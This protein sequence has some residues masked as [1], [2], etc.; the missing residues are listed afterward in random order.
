MHK[1][2]V[3]ILFGGHSSEY[4]VSLHSVASVIENIDTKKYEIFLFGI[5]Q[6]GN[7]M[8]YEGDVTSIENDTWHQYASA[9][10]LSLNP[11]D[12]GFYVFK[13]QSFS[14]RQVDVVFPV[15]HG[16]YGEDGTLQGALSMAQ[17]PYVGCDT[18]SSSVSMDKEFTHILC[19]RFNI[20]MAPYYALRCNDEY[21]VDSLFDTV[22]KDLG[23][24][25]F[26]KPA[27]AGSSYGI[28]KVNNLEEFKIGIDLAFSHDS[29]L[30]VEK[31]I[32]GFEV[33][34][35]ILGNNKIIIGE[36]DEIETH[37]DFFDFEGKYEMN[38][39]KIHCPAR[40]SEEKKEEIK[41]YAKEIYHIL[42]CTGFSR[43][44][45]FI[46]YE[47]NI[48]FNE[49]NTIPGFTAMSRYP[50]MMSKIGLNFTELIDQLLLLA[51]ED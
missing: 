29:K 34:C 42:G 8:Y 10:T 24:P 3:A 6:A 15:M 46:D 50:S 16:K 14:L 18:L 31:A 41:V 30:L 45:F 19:E 22:S 39:S 44:D 43:I 13:D 36:I 40:I 38:D 27:N 28:S 33:G 51:L 12:R 48:V 2:K 7:M 9:A 37:R 26:I 4:S 17:I 5:T 35:A 47:K 1:I 25:L 23:L 11:L 49:L 32:T 20:P 21:H